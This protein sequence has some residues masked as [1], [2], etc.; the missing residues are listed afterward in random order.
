MPLNPRL[1]EDFIHRIRSAMPGE[2]DDAT[3]ISHGVR[4]NVR[5]ALSALLGSMDLV[6]REE[7]EVQ[8]ELLNRAYA[9]IERLEAKLTDQEQG[10][11][12]RPD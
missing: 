3:A 9:R 10:D 4:E 8:S 5:E 7:F 2:L 11:A 1:V 6:T 12:A